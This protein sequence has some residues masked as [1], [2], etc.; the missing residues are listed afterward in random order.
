MAGALNDLMAA[1]K[2]GRGEVVVYG[3]K[4]LLTGFTL[5]C[6]RQSGIRIDYL[7]DGR[8]ELQGGEL[9]GLP[10]IGPEEL[11]AQHQDAHVFIC[12]TR[13]YWTVYDLLTKLGMGNL[14]SLIDISA[15][16]AQIATDSGDFI[17]YQLETHTH[18]VKS[19]FEELS[20]PFVNFIVTEQC[21]LS[22]KECINLIPHIRKKKH[23]P[24]EQLLRC[25]ANLLQSLGYLTAATLIGGE[26]FV[27]P[28][29][30]EL[31]E[32]LS[33]SEKIGRIEI[34]TNGTV[35]PEKQVL[36]RFK[37]DKRV[38]ISISEYPGIT[39][40]IPALLKMAE[41]FS[42]PCT[43]LPFMEW[44]NMGDLSCRNRT[45]DQLRTVFSNCSVKSCPTIIGGKLYRCARAAFGVRLGAIPNAADEEID[46]D[47]TSP[48]HDNQ[49][50][51][52]SLFFHRDYLLAC[53]YCDGCDIS[54]PP[55][56]PAVQT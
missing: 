5:K 52:R 7:A 24:A 44:S 53:N 21:T 28:E 42:V 26:P 29:L 47:S 18:V 23:Y 25:S 34:V 12:L 3:A 17:R 41:A 19:R 43:V 14:Y 36:A 38:H 48:T 56:P 30:A 20:L 55:I 16:C 13:E 4:S 9:H 45:V 54:T 6:L 2:S 10:V 1:Q 51:I 37:P 50:K 31:V 15:S 27:Y 39:H 33:K 46:L 8:K 32:G 35:L 11:A 22:C 49:E 40:K